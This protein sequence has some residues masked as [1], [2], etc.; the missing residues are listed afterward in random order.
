MDTMQVVFV[1]P[2]DSMNGSAWVR[3]M[4]GLCFSQQLSKSS[5]KSNCPICINHSDSSNQRMPKVPKV[6]DCSIACIIVN[7]YIYV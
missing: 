1:I 6:G 2:G 5:L 7:V 4:V 3:K